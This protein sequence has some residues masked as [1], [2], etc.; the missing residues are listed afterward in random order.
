MKITMR[1][2]RIHDLDLLYLYKLPDFSIQKAIKNALKAYI[3]GQDLTIDYPTTDDLLLPKTAMIHIYLSEKKDAEIIAWLKNIS[4]GYRNS[5]LKNIVRSYLK[6]PGIEPYLLD[7]N[8]Q[9]YGLL[10]KNN[11]QESDISNK[12]INEFHLDGFNNDNELNKIQEEQKEDIKDEAILETEN[13]TEE[14]FDLFSTFDDIM[15]S[16]G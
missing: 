3:S 6:E 9:M 14:D 8:I 13:K 7:N 5:L 12:I 4:K 15:S 16:F 11:K 10:P 2:Y 1:L